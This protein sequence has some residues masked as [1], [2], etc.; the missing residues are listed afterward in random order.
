MGAIR[1]VGTSVQ[2]RI[3]Q[4]CSTPTEV[5]TSRYLKPVLLNPSLHEEI[6][7]GTLGSLGMVGGSNPL[8]LLGLA[9]IFLVCLIA[10][11]HLLRKGISKERSTH[12]GK[13]FKTT[14]SLFTSIHEAVHEFVVSFGAGFLGGTIPSILP[15][16]L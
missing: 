12:M 7:L 8:V 9:L 11:K 14:T 5:L 1:A 15:S 3:V 13:K 10:S 6:Q 4:H 16:R 2:E